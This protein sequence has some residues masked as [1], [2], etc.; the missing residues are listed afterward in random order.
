MST[1]E[2]LEKENKELT[3]TVNKLQHEFDTTRGLWCID[4]SPQD[5]SI[6]WVRENAFQL[7]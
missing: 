7:T 6:E 5:V 3:E 4:K 2:I 1:V